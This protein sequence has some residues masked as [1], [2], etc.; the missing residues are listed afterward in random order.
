VDID[1]I[2]KE[3]RIIATTYATVAKANGAK[4]TMPTSKRGW[5]KVT[6]SMIRPVQEPLEF[7]KLLLTITDS[8]TETM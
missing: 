1:S 4:T 7:S 2:D 5:K 8:R 3:Q 6:S